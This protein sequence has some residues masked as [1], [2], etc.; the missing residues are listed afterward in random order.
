MIDFELSQEYDVCFDK[1][2]RLYDCVPCVNKT[3]VYKFGSKIFLT[4][5]FF[6]VSSAISSDLNFEIDQAPVW[7][8]VDACQPRMVDENRLSLDSSLK[9]VRDLP[10]SWWKEYGADRPEQITFDNVSR[11]L[12]ANKNDALFE[13][14]EIL[15]EP[16]ATLLIEWRLDS[17]MCSLNIGEKEFSYSILSFSNMDN[18]LLGQASVKDGNAIQEFFNRLGSVYA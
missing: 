2:F 13:G 14:A 7:E 4:F 3:A 17:F 15:A 5:S 1:D 6:V 18:P 16:N 11:F 9:A 8:C 12:D 10:D